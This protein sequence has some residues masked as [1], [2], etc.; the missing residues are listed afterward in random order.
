MESTGNA[1]KSLFSLEGKVA[2]VTGGGGVLA[3]AIAYGLAKAGASVALL[4]LREEAA[5]ARADDLIAAGLR[6][7][8]VGADCL[9]QGALRTALK[10]VVTDLGPVDVLVNT[11]GGN[12]KEAT[13]APDTTVFGMPVQAL[14]RVVELNLVAGTVLPSQ[15][16]GEHMASH[17]RP[18]SIINI[19][20][21][22]ASRPL[23]RV[24]GYGAAKAAVDNFTRWLAVHFAMD[25]KIPVRV[26]AIAPGFFITEQNRFLL[27]TDGTTLTPRGETILAHTPM[28]RFGEPDDLVG[29][30]VW[31]AGDASAFVTGT[32]IPID[33][34]FSAFS[35][36]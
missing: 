21:M 34:G 24:V 7:I 13:V 1:G 20:S 22:A 33:G 2:V 9:D 12:V 11:A 31:L 28:G 6:C 17:G 32:I 35:G 29:A 36:V 15:V 16:F 23:T 26:N 19:S 25:L 27:T 5:W 3:G 4:D 8:G 18:S 14:K 30:A 10:T